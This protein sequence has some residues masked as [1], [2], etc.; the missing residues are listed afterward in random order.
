MWPFSKK[1][2]EDQEVKDQEV[3]DAEQVGAAGS[4]ASVGNTSSAEDAQAGAAAAAPQAEFTAFSIDHD[5]VNGDSG[6]FDGDSV[7]IEEFDF[8]DFSVGILDLGSMRIPL[9]KGSQVQVEMGEQGPKMLHIVTEFGRMTPVAFA[10]PRKPGQ[11]AES[12]VD[13]VEGL[14]RDGF[15]AHP[16]NGPWGTEVVGTN[17]NG[18]IRIIGVDGPRWMYRLTLAAP[19]G[20]Q[21]ELAALGREVFAR[22]FVYRGENPVLAGSSLPVTLPQQLAEQVQTAM[23]QR[24]EGGSAPAS[25]APGSADAAN[26]AAA[27]DEAEAKAQINDLNKETAAQENS[28]D[29]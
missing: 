1:K 25:G 4:P 14:T 26:S 9:P 17:P 21:E 10:A 7:K 24:A 16:E 12:A 27:R 5:A 18:E 11:W 6:P 22:T 8:T 2:S 28:D 20:K 13:I 29:K 15:T 23:Q 3:K 19:A